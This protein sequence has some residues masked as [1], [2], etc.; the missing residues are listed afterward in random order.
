MPMISSFKSIKNRHDVYRGIDCMKKFCKSLRKHRMEIIH[1]QMKKLKLSI[2][3]QHQS[4]KTA[5]ICYI[6]K[7]KFENKYVKDKKC[8]KVRDHCHPTGQY[9]GSVHSMYNLKCSVLKRTSIAFHNGS[10]YDYDFL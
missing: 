6:C 7:Y 3:K 2:K 8:C 9:R 4:Y 1:F 10:N 5:N